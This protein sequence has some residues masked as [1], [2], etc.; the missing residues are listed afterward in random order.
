MEKRYPFP[1]Q[2]YQTCSPGRNGFAFAITDGRRSLA[3][4]LTENDR[5]IAEAHA[6]SIIH[7]LE[8]GS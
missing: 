2:Y 1:L 8:S 5:K 7:E 6:V 3:V 4:T